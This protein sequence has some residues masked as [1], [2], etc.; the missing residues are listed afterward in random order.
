MMLSRCHLE[1]SMKIQNVC[2]TLI[3]VGLLAAAPANLSMAQS[4]GPG[5]PTAKESA[6]SASEKAAPNRNMNPTKH[7][8]WRHRGGRHPHYGGRPVRT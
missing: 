4:S 2:R 5:T 1:A 3:L 6:T 7:R 8:H